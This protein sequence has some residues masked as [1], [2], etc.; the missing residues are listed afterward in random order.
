[1]R[2]IPISVSRCSPAYELKGDELD[3]QT[4]NPVLRATSTLSVCAAAWVLIGAL[5]KNP[6]QYYSMLRWLTCSAA[7]VLVW[8][9]VIQGSCKWAY[10]LVPIAII[11]NPIVPIYLHGERLAI[12]RTWQTLDVVAAVVMVLIVALME[13]Q[14][15]IAKKR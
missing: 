10:L 14:V 4:S 5:E 12:L 3:N 13:L 2:R 9:G 7:A 1:M 15:V 8:R 6:I 11:F